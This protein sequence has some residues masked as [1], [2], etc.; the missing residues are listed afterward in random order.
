MY[1]NVRQRQHL[2]DCYNT[3]RPKE[4][5][6]EAVTVTYAAQA[7]SDVCENIDWEDACAVC[8]RIS[9]GQVQFRRL[10]R[11]SAAKT[12]REF[13]QKMIGEI[14]ADL[15]QAQKKGFY[16]Q[17]ID[18]AQR[19]TGCCGL[20]S[21]ETAKRAAL[22]EEEMERECAA[23][24]E[25]MEEKIF[26]QLR[27]VMA[28]ASLRGPYQD[29]GEKQKE[30]SENG[31]FLFAVAQYASCAN[32]IFQHNL[33]QYPELM[34]ACAA[35][36]TVIKENWTRETENFCPDDQSQIWNVM[37]HV[38]LG[39]I[40][41]AMVFAVGMEEELISDAV[42]ELLDEGMLGVTVG[43]LIAV[44]I[45]GLD[46]LGGIFILRAAERAFK[47]CRA[48]KIPAAKHRADCGGTQEQKQD[49]MDW[50]KTEV[51]V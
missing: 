6:E 8:G 16:L 25:S 12:S 28:D 23:Q 18:T 15:T 42:F 44:S 49:E 20:H 27:D 33:V 45:W 7:L 19:E 43:T 35:G 2:K 29:T 17:W 14:T 9:S 50:M 24:I 1:F 4:P 37:R 5:Q 46:S 32:G 3:I 30:F 36:Q 11:G 38:I 26:W 22:S 21:A 34:G 41:T 51:R 40:G 39:V 31:S 47:R 48:E 13:A 10:L